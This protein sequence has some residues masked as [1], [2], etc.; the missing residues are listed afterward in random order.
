[1]TD[2]TEH[3]ECDEEL[4]ELQSDVIKG[5]VVGLALERILIYSFPKNE[6]L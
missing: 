1:M 6:K 5:I 2:G 4:Q 3:D